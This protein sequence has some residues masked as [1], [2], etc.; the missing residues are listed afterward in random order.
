MSNHGCRRFVER[1]A[2]L[3]VLAAGGV[4][5]SCGGGGGAPADTGGPAD[6]PGGP[7]GSGPDGRSDARLDGPGGRDVPAADVF[8]V[9]PG[10]GAARQF[11]AACETGA[12]CDSGWCVAWDE[13]HVCSERCLETCPAGWDCLALPATWPDVAF[14]CHWSESFLCRACA[15]DAQCG[16]GACLALEDG[17]RC[18]R[19][20]AGAEDCPDGFVCEERADAKAGA[21]R[22]CAPLSGRCDC[23]T[24]SVGQQRPCTIENE[25]GL[26]RGVQACEGLTGWSSC[27]ARTPAAETCN[28]VDDD[29]DALVDEQPTAPAE[30]CERRNA[31]GAC[32]GSWVCRGVAGWE[33]TVLADPAAETCDLTDE[34]CDGETDEDFRDASGAY[35]A[36]AHCGACG[37][38]CTGRFPFGTG[39]CV[40]GEDGP[41]CVVTACAPGFFQAGPTTCLPLTS[42]LC[43]PCLQDANCAVPGDR[44][45]TVEEGL[46][47]GRDCSPASLHG[48]ECP[49]G[50]AC[51]AVEGGA[52]QCLPRSGSCSCTMENADLQRR[53][54]RTNELGTC[55]GV[56]RCDPLLGWSECDAPEAAAEVC[57]G[58]DDDCD[59]FVDEALTPPA[60]A[61]ETTWTAPDGSVTYTCGGEW[62]CV[63]AAGLTDWVCTAPPAG[64]EVC[65]GVD[66]D[67]DGAV[68]ED[69]RDALT[70]RYVQDDHCGACGFS[71]EGVIPNGT[72]RCDG[73][74]DP[75][76]C[77][78]A[79]C[80]EGFYALGDLACLPVVD[81]TCQPC[82]SDAN[83]R[84]PGS[85]CLI[86]TDGR[87]CGRDC[88]PANVFGAPEGECPEGQECVER[89]D[90]RRQC[91]PQTG[92]CTCWRPDQSGDRR[93]CS[94]TNAAGSCGGLETCRPDQGGWGGCTAATPQLE[95]CDGVDEDCDGLVDEGAPPPD[96]PCAV[97]NEWGVCAADWRCRGAGGWSCPAATPAEDL[98]NGLD[99]DC[100]GGTDEDFRADGTGPYT[101]FDNC[102][103]CGFSCAG[104]VLHA[105]EIA[106]RP[107]GAT[108]RCVPVSCEDGYFT[109][110][111]NDRVCIPAGTA[112]DCQPCAVPEHCSGLPGGACQTIDGSTFCT[113]GCALDAECPES[114]R[115]RSGRCWPDSLSCTCHSGNEGERRPC[116]VETV[117]GVCQGFQTC[118]PLGVPGWSVCDAP[119][120]SAEACNG[121]DDNCNGLVDEGVTHDPPQCANTGEWG[122]CPGMWVCADDGAGGR[123]WTCAAPTATRELCNGQDDDC[124]GLTDE[125]FPNLRTACA[126]GVGGCR[127]FGIYECTADG[128][129]TTCN[130]VAGQ[131]GT[132]V[133]NG[134]DD[135][136]DGLT[137]EGG[138]WF[139]RGSVCTAGL[140]VCARVGVKICDPDNLAGPTVCSIAPGPAATEVCNGLDDDCDGLT[141]EGPLWAEKRAPCTA[142]T[143]TCRAIGVY[144]CDAADPAGAL[145]CTAQPA[146]AGTES[147][148]G[149]DDDC[150]GQTDEAAEL[151]PP[152]CAEQR[153]VCAGA[154]QVC[155]GLDGWAACRGPE[156]GPLFEAVEVS[157][158][159]LDNDCDGQTD[160]ALARPPCQLQTGVCAG[161]LKTCG[162]AQG[163][164]ECPTSA[165]GPLYQAA[166]TTCDYV[167][168]DCDGATDEGYRVGG[169]Y[170]HQDHCGVCGN[171]CTGAIPNATTFCDAARGTPRCAVASCAPGYVPFD[172]Y[173]CVAPTLGQCAPCAADEDCP[174]PGA[175]CVALDDGSFCVNPCDVLGDCPA[176][177]TCQEVAGDGVCLPDTGA[178]QC[179]GS[180][181]TLTRVCQA[182]YPADGDP[183]YF[184][185]GSSAC[186]ASGWGTCQLP[187]EICDAFD[188]DCDGQVDEGFVDAQGRY[189]ADTNCGE[190]GNDCTGIDLPGGVAACDGAREPP[191]CRFACHPNCFDVNRNLGDGCECCDPQPTDAPDP[192]GYDANCDGMDGERTNGVFVAKDGD[193]ANDGTHGRPKR[194]IQAGI[195]TAVAR[196][197]PYVYVAT[198]VY[199]EAVRLRAGVQVYGGYRSDFERR[200]AALYQVAILAPQPTAALPGAVNAI[201]LRGGASGSAVFDG[202]TVFG[203]QVRI[204]GASSYAVYV[205]NC[206]ATVRIANNQVLAGSGGDGQRGT[207][208][209]NG[210]GGGAGSPGRDA[211][212]NPTDVCTVA[213]WSL[214]GAAGQGT[215]GGLSTSGGAGGLRGCPVYDAGLDTTEPPTAAES[216]ARG[217]D[218]GVAGGGG[219]G[220]AAGWDVWQ[221]G[222]SC[223]PYK[224]FGPVEGLE[225]ADGGRGPNGGAGT[226]CSLGGAIAAGGLWVPGAAGAGGHGAAGAGGGGGGSGGGAQ[227]QQSCRGTQSSKYGYDN[228]GGTGGGGGAGGCGGTGGTGGT[229]GGGA[230]AIFVLFETPPVT[231]PQLA[232]N[233]LWG[234]VGGDGGPGGAGGVSGNGGAGAAGG[235]GGD[236][237]PAWSHPSFK[238]GKGGNGGNG[239]HGGGGG[240]GCGGPAYGVF[241]WGAGAQDLSAWRSGNTFAAPGRGG[242]GGVGGFSLGAPG[243]A[244]P[245][246]A[247]TEANF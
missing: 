54:D 9:R 63:T 66:D 117:D 121:L 45:V 90:G 140:G 139:D 8:V 88:G 124:D 227:V 36:D 218:G 161:A 111:S 137:D 170:T 202:F 26:C 75:P 219:T 84:T 57:N 240:G 230:F 213:Q 193:D 61:C 136:C 144:V 24:A 246:G 18:G 216:G 109:P 134:L 245:A 225:G 138:P 35:V 226:A 166:E 69:F 25:H 217:A 120:P 182:Q 86:L 102:G 176:G 29:C 130:A 125:E 162:G 181:L 123:G 55:P 171:S 122:S 128:E 37:N 62:R 190:C 191:A 229:G 14:A 77:A 70:G 82:G 198:G 241:A 30:V 100:D 51:T 68:D 200:D 21:A 110:P 195:D 40:L 203:A 38:A 194:T 243:E 156:Y 32:V 85:A 80:A 98:C 205:R 64:P 56:H 107:R 212:D 41:E 95:T 129:R 23:T 131:P 7:D 157:C 210:V 247:A 234:G 223:V 119:I 175:L 114:Y 71:C 58:A 105:T 65:N 244:G 127:R 184:C 204:L 228:F 20:C 233:L 10:A 154:R 92:Q 163:W 242:A 231:V 148:N 76:T 6:V 172:G 224:T 5:M 209:T 168:N 158:D 196:G 149:L 47:C 232:G 93:P 188:N 83:C 39:A 74:K 115:C 19:P 91:R 179:D 78:V 31:F 87:F 79:T 103:L 94:V 50:Y 27:T 12:D 96:E 169:V 152:L 173:G 135:D 207:D 177:A 155:R 104:T 3:V 97:A 17:A 33:C 60:A 146:A 239:G 2:L 185:D 132:E 101:D 49:P 222:F 199:G 67:C 108:A 153:G 201:D 147:C 53:C 237:P 112:V 160:E 46:F 142:G 16:A 106:C 59:G 174:L 165:Y 81:P 206:D 235:A 151:A 1:A 126:V 178:C 72:A 28:G 214:G 187:A 42:S 22:Q 4:L 52:P 221:Q 189:T 215:C 73:S 220:G 183:Q 13:G 48:T 145:R 143:G 99:D 167:D 141:D 34:D 15:D 11:G 236:P 113:R 44:C 164:L 238:G 197:V 150:D 180:N 211:F 159:G 118:D 43:L 133:C 116:R 208:G 89:V 192:L 186:T